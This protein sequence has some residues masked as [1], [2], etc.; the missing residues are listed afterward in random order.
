MAV[1]IFA[2]FVAKEVQQFAVYES[3]RLMPASARDVYAEKIERLTKGSQ[4]R[5][6]WLIAEV[7]ESAKD[8]PP[9]PEIERLYFARYP[10]AG[11]RG[12][13]RCGGTGWEEVT[14]SGWDSKL[15]Y[16]GLRRCACRNGGSSRETPRKT[17]TDAAGS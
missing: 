11:I 3:W 13:E 6:T 8:L 9:L 12:C 10:P 4:A 7:I 15:A 16:S 1:D 14:G 2:R 17:A 5:V